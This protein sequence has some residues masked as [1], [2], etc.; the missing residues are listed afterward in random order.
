MTIQNGDFAA[1]PL[2]LIPTSA[3]RNCCLE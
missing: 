3:P 1:E 2:T